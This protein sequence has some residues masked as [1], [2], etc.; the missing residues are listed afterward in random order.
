MTR[1]FRALAFAM[2]L[3]TPLAAQDGVRTGISYGPPGVRP[4]IVVAA[5]PGLDS[6]RA[7]IERDLQFSDR[8]EVI[9]LPDSSTRI[10]GGVQLGIYRLLGA[11]AVVELQPAPGGVEVKLHNVATGAIAEQ[12]IRAL[13]RGGVGDG[14]MAIHRVSDEIVAWVTGAKGIAA[15]RIL[16]KL[17]KTGGSDDGIFRIDSDGQNLVRVS[18]PGGI[19]QSPAWHPDGNRVAYTEM[20]DHVGTIVLQSLATGTRVTIPTTTTAQNYTAAISP[21][22]TRMAFTRSSEEGSD[23]YEV[24]LAQMCCVHR[25]TTVGRLAINLS[26]T[27][28]PD[29][30][31]IA[32]ISQRGGRPGLYVMDGDGS[33]Q[34]ALIFDADDTAESQAPDWSPDGTKIVFHRDLAGG[35]QITILDVARGTVRAVT[36]TGRNEDPSWAP[37]SRHVVFKSSRSGRDQLWVLDT[38]TGASRQISTPGGARVPAWS[39]SL[40]AS[41]P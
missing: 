28:S 27:Y 29:G 38:E 30:R 37:D 22:G 41:A 33:G 6:V 3:A 12:G 35:R 40:R 23:I 24:N 25:L 1:L 32:F 15:T 11:A 5:A 19:T 16:L 4:G 26:P 18:R 31:R 14:R 17:A 39:P 21:D 7:I 13:D 36:S 20:R 2:L 34:Q 10:A 9:I 8:F